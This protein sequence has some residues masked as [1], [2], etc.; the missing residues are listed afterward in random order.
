MD[1]EQDLEQELWRLRGVEYDLEQARIRI[2]ELEKANQLSADVARDAL[3]LEAETRKHLKD[4]INQHKNAAN[5]RN[6][7]MEEVHELKKKIERLHIALER[8]QRHEYM[9][10]N[11]GFEVVGEIPTADRGKRK[12]WRLTQ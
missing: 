5:E 2:A 6:K 3:S 9:Q 11:Y 10:E 1:L 7:Y 8:Y 12:G 4:E